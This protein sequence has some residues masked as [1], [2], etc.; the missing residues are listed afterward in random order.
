MPAQPANLLSHGAVDGQI[1]GMQPRHIEPGVVGRDEFGGD[2]IE[3]ERRGVDHARAGRAE[4]HD[5]ARHQRAREQA[6]RTARHQILAAHGDQVGCAGA[7]ADEVDG[8]GAMSSSKAAAA[9]A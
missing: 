8:H 2:G 4:C 1:T 3:V 6:H 5:L 9:V 7:G